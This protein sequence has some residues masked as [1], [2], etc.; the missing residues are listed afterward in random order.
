MVCVKQIQTASHIIF[1]VF[2]L[3]WSLGILAIYVSAETQF[4]VKSIQYYEGSS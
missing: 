3:A 1:H 2:L 4:D